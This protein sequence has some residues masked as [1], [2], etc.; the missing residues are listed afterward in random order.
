MAPISHRC[1]T[2]GHNGRIQRFDGGTN[3]K[4]YRLNRAE[5]KR[6]RSFEDRQLLKKEIATKVGV[7]QMRAPT[8]M[9][10]GMAAREKHANVATAYP[11]GARATSPGECI[12]REWA[13]PNPDEH[14]PVCIHREHWEAFLATRHIEVSRGPAV[15]KA[16]HVDLELVPVASLSD[17]P[18]VQVPAP[19]MYVLTLDGMPV[20]EATPAEVERAQTAAETDGMPLVDIGGQMYAV[21]EL[22]A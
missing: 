7:C 13:K 1:S 19:L 18:A 22:R 20:R 5:W 4:I 6:W 10:L 14:H 2:V 3:L 21:G 12:C 9:I 17:S 8:G 15:T 11:S 16:T